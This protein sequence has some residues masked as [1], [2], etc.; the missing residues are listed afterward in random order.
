MGK[1]IFCN[2]CGNVGCNQE[3][4][5]RCWQ[6][7]DGVFIAANIDSEIADAEV[8]KEYKEAHNGDYPSIEES[9]DHFPILYSTTQR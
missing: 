8:T 6:C 5:S 1:L 3:I 2:K 4:G 9:D 7:D